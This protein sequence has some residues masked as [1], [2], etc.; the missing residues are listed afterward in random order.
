MPFL[1]HWAAFPEF[2]PLAGRGRDGHAKTGG[3]LPPLPFQRRMWAGGKLEFDG[4]LRIAE[5]VWR[6]ST[7]AAISQKEGASGPMAFVTVTHEIEGRDSGA[8]I[9]ER[10]DIVYLDIPET[11]SP[12]TRKPV[13]ETLAWDETVLMNEVRLFQYSAATYNGHRIHYDLPYAQSVEKYPALVVHGP[14]QATLALD[15]AIR[16]TGHKPASFSYRGLHPMFH[17]QNLR[18][19]GFAT[20]TPGETGLASASPEGH[21]GLTA[22]MEWKT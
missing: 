15:A 10:Q 21:L 17:D 2:T 6:R 16:H 8:R 3:F 20:D 14:M 7:I 11:F 19:I 5:P 12:P 4:V 18:L 9:S 1:W 22:K 13:P